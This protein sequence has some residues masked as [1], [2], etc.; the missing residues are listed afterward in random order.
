MLQSHMPF[1]ADLL[2]RT[3]PIAMLSL[4]AIAVPVLVLAPDGF[5]HLQALQRQLADVR[6]DNE[7]LRRDVARLRVEV[8][9]LRDDPASVERI[10]RDELG[11]V[12]KNEVVFQ[13]T[14]P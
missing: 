14:R 5:P 10:A 11:M 12:R 7:Q 6:A 9:R 1:A 3:L 2:R 4:A 13:F 8:A